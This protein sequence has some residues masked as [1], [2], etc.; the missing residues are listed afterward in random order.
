VADT[1]TL[2]GQTVSHYRILERLG[3]GGMGVVY[4][5]EDT[6]LRRFVALKFLPDNVA[7]NPQALARFQRE[8]QAASALNHPNICTI[9]DIGEENGRAFIAMEYLEG[10]TLKHIIAGRPMELERLLN[11]AINVAD[12][13]NAAHSKGIVHR[14]IKPANIFVTEAGHAKILDFGLAKVASVKGAK[15][16]EPTLATQEIDPEHLTSPGSTLGTVAYMSPEQ[17]RSKELDARTD[18]FSF[19]TVLYEIATGSLPFHAETSGMIFNAILNREPTPPLRV[20]PAMPQDLARVISKAL[21]KD[22]EVRYQHASELRADLKR[23]RRDATS[24][25]V[26]TF[27]ERAE[28]PAS[29]KRTFTVLAAV[30][31][32]LLFTAVVLYRSEMNKRPPAGSEWV[33]LTNLVDSATSPAL[34]PD[35]RMLVFL[36]GSSTFVGKSEI[37]LRMLSGG[38][39]IALTHDATSKMSPVFSPDGSQIAYT[40][41]ARWDTWILP[42]LGG[43]PQLLL[44]NASGLTFDRPA[45][46]PFLRT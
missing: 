26:Q 38:E 16:D 18:L 28:R 35:G 46:F 23:L 1:D 17:V 33:Q 14:D 15:S 7:R 3:G 22:R 20:N 29:W 2:I 8:A 34:S 21:E 37:Y 44:P 36:R 12:G 25:K 43:E 11:V 32:V 13:L 6:R 24:G 19:G 41:P 10:K 45:S 39:P 31:V 27:E 30:A 9:H 40:I 42:T 4:K 5:A